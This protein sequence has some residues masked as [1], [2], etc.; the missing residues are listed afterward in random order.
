MSFNPLHKLRKWACRQDTESLLLPLGVS[1]EYQLTLLLH[2]FN[3]CSLRTSL[4]PALCQELGNQTQ[5]HPQ[6]SYLPYRKSNSK[7]RVMIQLLGA[8]SKRSPGAMEATIKGTFKLGIE[9]PIRI[10]QAGRQKRIPQQRQQDPF[11]PQA[12]TEVQLCTRL[13]TGYWK[14][15]P[16]VNI[17]FQASPLTCH[18]NQESCNSHAQGHGRELKQ[19]AAGKIF[20]AMHVKCLA[21]CLEYNKYPVK[22]TYHYF[23]MSYFILKI[24]VLFQIPF[25]NKAVFVSI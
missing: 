23:Y 24:L 1:S 20:K 22:A 6:R 8:G 19:S 9:G 12:F 4:R 16:Q 25:H 2:S 17:P 5:P 10:H 21:Q 15:R 18:K 11:F 3:K 14:C 7:Q 13:I